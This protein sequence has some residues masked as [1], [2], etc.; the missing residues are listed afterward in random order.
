MGENIVGAA[1]LMVQVIKYWEK[2]WVGAP[3]GPGKGWKI[4]SSWLHNPKA[5]IML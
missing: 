2:T 4:K 5:P 1:I 3:K